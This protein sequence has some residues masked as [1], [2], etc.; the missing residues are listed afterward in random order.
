MNAKPLLSTL[1]CSVVLAA[2][3]SPP[4]SASPPAA[5]PTMQSGVYARNLDTTVRAQDDFY[6]F[7]NGKWLTNT[8]IPADRSNYGAFALLEDEAEQDL[9]AILD[10]A[11]AA[12]APA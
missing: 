2:C 5:Q 1:S 9:K 3:M 8:A 11:S 10:E 6:R 12:S 7:V 4:P